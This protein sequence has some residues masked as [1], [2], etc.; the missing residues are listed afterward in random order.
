M[1]KQ[2]KLIVAVVFAGFASVYVVAGAPTAVAVFAVQVLFTLRRSWWLLPVQ[3]VLAYGSVL[4]FGSSVGILGFVGGSLLLTRLWPLALAVAGSAALLGP[5][6]PVISMVLISLVVYGL[7]R[8]IDRIDEVN[9][10]RLSL[11]VTAAAEERLRIAA[12]LSAGLGRAL[13]AIAEGARTGTPDVETARRSLAE[14]RSAAAS[15]RAMSLT[16]EITTAKAMLTAAGVTVDVRVSHAEPLGPAGALLAAVLREAVTDIVRRSAAGSRTV[17]RIETYTEGAAVWLR[18]SDDGARTAGDAD[19][20]DLPEQVEAAGGTLTVGLTGDARMSV[21]A[22]LPV[23]R[24]AGR[25]ERDSALA[26]ALLAA[27]LVGFSVKALLAAGSLWPAPLLA[28]IVVMQ[29][30]SVEGRHH[31]ALSIMGV[32][33]F[34]PLPLFG[35][36]WLGVAGFLAGPVLLAFPWAVALPLVAAV[37]AVVA[38]SGV[39]LALPV[40]LTVNYAI[41][42]VV[43]GLVVYGLLR[44][45]RMAGELRES[46]DGLARAAVVE[47]RLRAARDLHDLLGHTLA[48]ILLKCELARRLD[49]DRA[50]KELQDVLT[51]TERAMEDLRTVS[52]RDGELSLGAEAE[53]AR[54]L[55]STAGVEVELDLGH[56]ALGRDVETTLGIV[57]REAVTNVLRHS[58]ARRCVITTSVRDGTVRLSV[59]N[60]GARA[61]KGRHGSAG[62]GNLTTRLAAL[63]GRLDVTHEDGWFELTAEAPTLTWAPAGQVQAG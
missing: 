15:Y 39:L 11:A 6:D 41:S 57:L 62:I 52:G 28:V 44:L 32:L 35:Q 43:T 49:A 51:M 31:V 21:E 60:D 7:T 27:V 25:P 12:E 40:A 56:D 45:A 47:E 59:R 38:V 8:M 34:A 4:L 63:D 1:H 58:S 54:A 24:P 37:V 36:A 50:R 18:V 61:T 42:T 26:I 19:L 55:L 46:R 3:A 14:A 53:S 10:A 22:R 5:P 30:R 23:T 29:V 2:A 13:S 9:A 20:G 17:C 48:A 33:T 16:P